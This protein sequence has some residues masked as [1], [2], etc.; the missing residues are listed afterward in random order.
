ML[1]T[2][3][4]GIK[5][6]KKEKLEFLNKTTTD[7]IHLDIMDGNFV[8][9]KVGNI[10][11]LK[12]LFLYNNKPIDIH[13]MVHDIESYIKEYS[14]L[15][16]MFM[17]FHIEVCNHPDMII[18]LLKINGIKA[19]IAI[20]PDTSL[21]MIM[22]YLKDIDL[23]LVMSVEAGKGGQSFQDK[24]VE[25]IQ[26]LKE[27]RE[28]SYL[29]YKIEVDGGINDTT[30]EKVKDVDIVVVGS[31]ITNYDNYQEQIDKLNIKG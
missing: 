19:G 10:E 8:S 20:N 2:S 18:K 13:F 6:N 21:D 29:D 16:P 9:N 23:V 11:E 3:I 24:I 12:E 28:K 26:F 4:L 5:E 30:I 1:A 17:T 27:Y 22:P 7:Y 15:K 31:F 14:V 25:K